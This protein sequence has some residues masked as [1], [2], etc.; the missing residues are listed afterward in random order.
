MKQYKLTAS[1]VVVI[2]LVG[3]GSVAPAGAEDP[4]LDSEQLLSVIEAV[5]PEVLEN[6]VP[7]S[8]TAEEAAAFSTEQTEVTVPRSAD[9]EATLSGLDRELQ[10]SLP[11]ADQASDAVITDEG[12]ATFDNNNGSA[13]VPIVREDGSLQ[14]L[15]VIEGPEAPTRYDYEISVPEGGSMEL[16]EGGAVLITDGDSNFVGAVAP[17]WAKDATGASLPTHYEVEGETLTQVVE[18]SAGTDYPVVADPWFGIQLFFN[19]TRGSWRGDFTYSGT[20]TV[21]GAAV[22]SGGGGIGGYFVGQAIFRANGWDEWRVRFGSDAMT[23]KA[24]LKQQYDCHV[25][26]GLAGLPFTGPYNLERAQTNRANWGSN[27][28]IHRCNWTP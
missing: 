4:S 18:H 22:L 21:A 16:I 5:V 1:V 14:I 3:F 12:I 25:A 9:D 19:F 6:T 2:G 11:F 10:I 26:A 8:S 28:H 20:V 23:N 15:T 27:V 17:P 7:P 13:T 24:T